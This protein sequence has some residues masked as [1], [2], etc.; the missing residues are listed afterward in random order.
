[1]DPTQASQMIGWL[2]EEL[3]KSKAQVSELRDLLQKQAIELADQRKRFEDRTGRQTRLQA[4]VVRMTQVDQAI[5]Q[6]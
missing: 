6:L 3:R 5:Q 2:D 4:D 1:M